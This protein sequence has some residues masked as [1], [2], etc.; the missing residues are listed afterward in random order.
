M[1]RLEGV[2]L[3]AIRI[4]MEEEEFAPIGLD[5]GKDVDITAI[6]DDKGNLIIVR[7]GANLKLHKYSNR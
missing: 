3:L 4:Q 6:D 5:F 2:N 1:E 7:F